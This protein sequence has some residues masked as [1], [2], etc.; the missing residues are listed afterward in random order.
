MGAR[1]D[2]LTDKQELYVQQLLLPKMTQ[3]KAYRIAYPSSVHWK[4]KSVDESASRTFHIPKVS[5][6]FNELKDKIDKKMEEKFMLT[7][8]DIL[9]DIIEVKERCMQ[10]Q[11]VMVKVNDELIDTGVWKFEHSG[12]L[13]SLELLGK[14]KKMFTDKI[15]L[16]GTLEVKDNLTDKELAEKIK[17]LQSKIKG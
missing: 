1:S 17:L 15:E 8:E 12:A 14:Y 7:V 10:Q 6:R 16:N 13:K 9:K 3:R 11:Q 4:D 5:A 2:K